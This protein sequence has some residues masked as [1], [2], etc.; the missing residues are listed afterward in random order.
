MLVRSA[1]RSVPK[2]AS[3][4]RSVSIHAVKGREIIDSRG[5]PTIEVDIT[6][7]QG[8]FRASV[9]SGAS[10]GIYEAV[11]L[12]DGDPKRFMGKGVEKAIN[13]VTGPIAAAVKGKSVLKQ[14]ECDQAMIATDG[15][16]N[17]SQFGATIH[18][19]TRV[20]TIVPGDHLRDHM[21]GHVWSL[22]ITYSSPLTIKGTQTHE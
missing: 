7:E 18:G 4:S 1:F 12:R 6:T 22:P 10:T 11:E 5:N 21:G 19:A 20:A 17:K 8:L 15:T 2:R 3:V 16:P 9:P 13:N 14:K